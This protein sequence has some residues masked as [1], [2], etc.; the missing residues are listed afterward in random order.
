MGQENRSANGKYK[1]ASLGR[2]F[3]VPTSNVIGF[4]GKTIM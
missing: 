4:H 3:P 1:R 2:L